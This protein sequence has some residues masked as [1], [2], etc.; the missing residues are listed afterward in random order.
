MRCFTVAD[1]AGLREK[2]RF[3]LDRVCSEGAACASSLERQRRRFDAGG[4][5]G[6]ISVIDAALLCAADAF[7]L[8]LIPQSRPTIEIMSNAG[9]L[10]IN[11]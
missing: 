6:A 11:C 2:T 8:R 4:A 3:V 9:F 5:D 10:Q 7:V 1:W